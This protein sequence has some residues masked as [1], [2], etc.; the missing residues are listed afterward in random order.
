MKLRLLLLLAAVSVSIGLGQAQDKDVLTDPKKKTSYAA[1]V[2]IGNNWKRQELDL[3]PDIVLQGVKDALG[4]RALIAEPELS[5]VLNAFSAENRAKREEKRKQLA[6]KNKQDGEKFLA[7][8]KTKPGVV[9]LPSGLQYKVLKEGS[10]ASPHANDSVSVNYRG[11]LID[12]TEFDSSA[13]RG[14]PATFGVSQVIAGWTEGLQ[15]MK[16]GSKYQLFIPTNLAYGERGQGN[17][18]G[19]N[20]A[21]IFDVELVSV[22]PAPPVP[23]PA[24]APVVTSDIIK[25]PS[26]EE[27]KKGAKIEIIKPDQIE[28]EKKQ[29]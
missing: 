17:L 18:I 13:K 1:G 19:P 4:G 7:D 21:L 15:K 12:G 25:V 23:T 11:T 29:P 5:E 20:A 2:S 14:Q 6:E 9:T 10:G 24:P 26:A 22:T 8:N 27:L 16:P 28:K 3:N